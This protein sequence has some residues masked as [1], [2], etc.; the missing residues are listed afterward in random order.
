MSDDKYKAAFKKLIVALEQFAEAGS[1]S[2]ALNTPEVLAELE[3]VGQPLL[4]AAT[5]CERIIN[6]L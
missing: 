6:E 4:D 3:R 1:R 5:E 2:P